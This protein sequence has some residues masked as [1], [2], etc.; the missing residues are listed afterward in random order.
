MGKKTLILTF[1][2]I[3]FFVSNT[4][5]IVN[6]QEGPIIEIVSPKNNETIYEKQPLIKAR[7]SSDVG[8]NLGTVKIIF[9]DFDVTRWEGDTTI[10]EEYVSHKVS[11]IF[12]LTEGKY[13][14]TVEVKDNNGAK[15]TE[16][17]SFKVEKETALK[18]GLGIDVLGIAINLV[19]GL[20]LGVIGLAI[21]ILYL[22]KTK[23][24]TFE[25]Y[26]AQHPLQKEYLVLYLPLSI[27]IIFLLFGFLYVGSN[28]GLPPFSYEYVAISAFCIGVGP[29]AIDSLLEKR[30]ILKNE[31]SFAQFL[32]EMADAMRGDR[33]SVV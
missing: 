2:L 7:Y 8:I 29:F 5:N 22:K 13:N 3:L 16:T 12:A 11:Q 15:T 19:I 25:K 28:S 26:F 30:K 4:T 18:Q 21:Y 33:K 23:G 20:G 1:I 24:F 17:W 6:A 27:A 9:N 32:F 31:R 10:T 14:V